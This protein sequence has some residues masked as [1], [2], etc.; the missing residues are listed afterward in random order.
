MSVMDRRLQLLLDAE[1]Y[2]RVSQE[3]AASGRSVAAVIREAIDAR[4]APD[5]DAALRAAG[6]EL[7][8][9]ARL[10]RADATHPGEG[11]DDLKRAYATSV[12]AKLARR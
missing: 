4:F 6:S 7:L 1:R 3:A 8:E 12:D 9:R 5:D 11:P 10:A 2:A